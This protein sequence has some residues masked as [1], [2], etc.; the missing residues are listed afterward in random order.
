MRKQIARKIGGF[1]LATLTIAVVI[2]GVLSERSIFA[3]LSERE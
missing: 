1:V 3:P 2:W